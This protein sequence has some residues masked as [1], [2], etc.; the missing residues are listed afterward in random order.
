[1]VLRLDPI[2]NLVKFSPIGHGHIYMDELDGQTNLYMTCVL[3]T[4]KSKN[5]GYY[6]VII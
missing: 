6:A 5:N 1:M 4:H 2:N 3:K